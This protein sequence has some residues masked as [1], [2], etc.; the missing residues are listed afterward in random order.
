MKQ[1]V[2]PLWDQPACWVEAKDWHYGL[3]E[4][5]ARLIA[6][7]YAPASMFQ[8]VGTDHSLGIAVKGGMSPSWTAGGTVKRALAGEG[9]DPFF[10]GSY[11]VWNRVNYRDFLDLCDGTWYRQPNG[12]YDILARYLNTGT[13]NWPYCA[14]KTQ[15]GT[16]SKYDGKNATYSGGVDVGPIAVSAQ[17]GWNQETKITWKVVNSRGTLLCGSEP[18][19]WVSAKEAQSKNP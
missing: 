3:Y 18:L 13:P 6:D 11:T 7:D 4:V 1:P 8:S 10:V 16:Y 17:S 5:F 2:S 14:H 19:G 12:T 15:L 9:A